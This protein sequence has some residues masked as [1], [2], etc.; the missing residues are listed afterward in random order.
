MKT[1][2]HGPEHRRVFLPRLTCISE[3]RDRT[4]APWSSTSIQLLLGAQGKKLII[5]LDSSLL[6][7]VFTNPSEHSLGSISRSYWKEKKDALSSPFDPSYD[8]VDFTL[9]VLDMMV[10]GK[11]VYFFNKY[12]LSSC[13]VIGTTRWEWSNENSR[14][15]LCSQGS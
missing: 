10:T 2:I 7:P 4:A 12:F 3:V 11:L 5:I 13:F 6:S 15:N 9:V 1:E 14:R 8:T